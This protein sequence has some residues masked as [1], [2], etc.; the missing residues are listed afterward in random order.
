MSSSWISWLFD[1]P[2]DSAT[3][4]PLVERLGWTLIHSLWQAT[5]IAG[6][7][8]LLLHATRGRSAQTR[9]LL[10]T[11]ALCVIAVLPIVTFCVVQLPSVVE[12]PRMAAGPVLVK[13]LGNPG[14]PRRDGSRSQ[15]GDDSG[16]WQSAD[17]PQ[18]EGNGVTESQERAM[19]GYAPLP[20]SQSDAP[21]T[22]A[23]E[24]ASGSRADALGWRTMLEP[25]LGTVVAIWLLGVVCFSFRPL[26]GWWIVR[27]FARRGALPAPEAFEQL[28]VDLSRRLGIGRATRVVLSTLINSPATIGWLMPLILLPESMLATL[29]LPQ[30]EAILAH[31]LAHIRRRDYLVNWMQMLVETLGFH[32]PAVWWVSRTMRRLREECCDDLAVAAIGDCAVYARALVAVEQHRSSTPVL[33]LS[34]RGGGLLARIQ[35]VMGREPASGMSLAWTAPMLLLLAMLVMAWIGVERGGVAAD[36]R[37]AAAPVLKLRDHMGKPIGGMI[38][39]GRRGY[40]D[41]PQRSPSWFA[42]PDGT[43]VLEGLSKGRHTVVVWQQSMATQVAV[44]S[45][46]SAEPTVVTMRAIPEWHEFRERNEPEFRVKVEEQDEEAFLR[47]EITN[48]ADKPITLDD[49]DVNVTT[50]VWQMFPP[51]AAWSGERLIPAHSTRVIRLSWSTIVRDGLW[52]PRYGEISEPWPAEDQTATHRYVR[53]N[54]GRWGMLPVLAPRPERILAMKKTAGEAPQPESSPPTGQITGRIRYAGSPPAEIVI[55]FAKP[56]LEAWQRDG[57]RGDSPHRPSWPALHFHSNYANTRIVDE[58]I[59]VGEDGGLANVLVWLRS[60]N[61]KPRL[62]DQLSPKARNAAQGAGRLEIHKGR[63]EPHVF[64]FIAADGLTLQNRDSGS[65]D[66]GANGI[67]SDFFRILVKP[68][69]SFKAPMRAERI[70]IQINSNIAPWMSAYALPLDHPCFA[71]T[72]K[73]G[74]FDIASIPPGEWELVFWHAAAGWLRTEQFP[75]GRKRMQFKAEKTDLGELIVGHSTLAPAA[76]RAAERPNDSLPLGN[77]GGIPHLAARRS[78]DLG[79]TDNSTSQKTVPSGLDVAE[80]EWTQAEY[81]VEYRLAFARLPEQNGKHPSFMADEQ[82]LLLFEIRNHGGRMQEVA[83]DLGIESHQSQH[84]VLI[85]GIEYVRND[86]PWGGLDRLQPGGSAVTFPILLSPDWKTAS[87][88][89]SQPLKLDAGTHRLALRVTLFEM[90]THV[91]DK[92]RANWRVRSGGER[93]L[94][95]KPIEF[96]VQPQSSSDSRATALKNIE[97]ELAV[98][99]RFHAAVVSRN[100]RG[101]TLEQRPDS[102]TRLLTLVRD[103]TMDSPD[104]ASLVFAA[105]WESLD[106]DERSRYLQAS[107]TSFANMRAKY[108]AGGDAA[109]AV[110]TRFRS[111]YAGLP[112]NRPITSETL[113]TTYL[114][115]QPVGTPF[116]YPL[117]TTVAHWLKTG[118][119]S[120]GRHAIRLVTDYQFQDGGEEYRGRYESPEY[121]FEVVVEKLPNT[122]VAPV[123]AEVRRL[124][125]ENFEMLETL[126]IEAGEGRSKVDM[127]ESA[128]K[129]EPQWRP[130]IRWN[131]QGE[132][133]A[134]GLHTPHW[135]LLSPLPVD[136]CFRAEWLIEATGESIAC[137]DIVVPAGQL[138]T[139]YFY[140]LANNPAD[141]RKSLKAAADDQGFVKLKI[142]L[143]PSY[144]LALTRTEVERYVDVAVVSTVMRARMVGK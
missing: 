38:V 140:P 81:G 102:I 44:E 39:A 123:T 141:L 75:T 90:E 105:I 124:F 95:T 41:E 58:S 84:R 56:D 66:V 14:P 93:S 9:Y 116:K 22:D 136:L 119:L 40:G 91:D 109:I 16:E 47:L 125:D 127:V 100:L 73:D 137:S 101:L 139:G 24:L 96:E 114:D 106:R 6:L 135:R 54:I 88:D 92:G 1:L 10:S 108:P 120:P 83:L 142:R 128:D 52:V 35:R 138:G 87:R 144:E 78:R 74:R 28:V 77:F 49:R 7:L 57:R 17:E 30:W 20:A 112:R 46:T 70:P 34:A 72:G 115:G 121:A 42:Q 65:L 32:H 110:G 36:P 48:R 103:G 129:I 18:T 132:E 61:S 51:A 80:G 131:A 62:A 8:A 50:P 107:M 99:P 111:D 67:A 4:R 11:A 31:E 59:V 113:T 133:P 25:W 126:P 64:A 15:R 37:S 85:D 12:K 43:V 45:P 86:Q 98:I 143:I 13:S 104:P 5:L 27:Q 117:H 76:P 79:S 130:L 71:V 97:Q 60:S 68:S 134:W 55:T 89:N 82:P 33:A 63:F 69:E 29:T 23:G 122:L 118:N 21:G 26:V 3:F 19:L 53:V 94:I 2:L